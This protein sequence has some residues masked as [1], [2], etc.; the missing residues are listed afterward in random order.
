MTSRTGETTVVA[1]R[2]TSAPQREQAHFRATATAELALDRWGGPTLV[3]H[4]ETDHRLGA[5]GAKVLLRLAGSGVAKR[6]GLN[7]PW[8][9]EGAGHACYM[10][11]HDAA[12]HAAVLGLVR[13][14]KPGDGYHGAVW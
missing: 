14:V 5:R 6:R 12:F 11:G 1:R 9:V 7:N 13:R 3:V 2:T 4:G 8:V 10:G